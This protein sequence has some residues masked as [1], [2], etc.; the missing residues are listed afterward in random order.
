MESF[1]AERTRGHAKD[2]VT[3][4]SGIVLDDDSP[5]DLGE[6]QIIASNS[7]TFTELVWNQ[8]PHTPSTLDAWLGKVGTHHRS[9]LS[10]SAR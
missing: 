1:L 9:S 10:S 3:D 7:A 6:Q 2:I 5:L 4:L 8:L